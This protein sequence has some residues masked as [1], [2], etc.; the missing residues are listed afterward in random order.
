[1][2][3]LELMRCHSCGT[4]NRVPREK[5]E[6]GLQPVCGRCKAPLTGGSNAGREAFPPTEPLH[7]TDANFSV[8]VERSPVPDCSTC[9]RR[10]A[11]HAGWSLR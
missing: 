6:Q 1:M 11:G 9:G 8:E 3:E 2:T 10:G 7:V 4:N 5:I